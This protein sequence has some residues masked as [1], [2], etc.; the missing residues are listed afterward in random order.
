MEILAP[1]GNIVQAR[2]AVEAGCDALYG[3]P[4]QWN[5]RNRA[6]NFTV[7]EYN[8]IIEYCHKNGV[9]FYLTLNTLLKNEEIES[10]MTLLS[11]GDLILPDAVIVADVGLMIELKK[12][13]PS[14]LIHSSTQFGTAEIRD[15][16]FLESLG[17]NRAILARELLLPEIER[18]CQNTYMEI[19]VFVYGSQCISFSG[20]CLW[21]GLLN[22]ASGNRGRC[23]GMCRDLYDHCGTVGQFLYPQDI[24]AVKFRDKLEKMNVKSL[25]IEG[26]MRSGEEISSVI[27]VLKSSEICDAEQYT[28]YLLQ[29]VPVK[30][31]FNSVNPRTKYQMTGLE[32][33]AH[34]LL[35]DENMKY[36]FGSSFKGKDTRFV[37]CI[38]Y[39][40]LISG[41]INFAIKAIVSCDRLIKIDYINTYGERRMFTLAEE[42]D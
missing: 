24:N 30:E 15:I 42:S 11:S 14:L 38:Y 18:I 1:A 3:G 8:Q 41:S 2:F 21:G 26:R 6:D 10:I 35:I 23:I 36:T 9:R 34:D 19:E 33:T 28:G 7:D 13:F 22:G 16:R 29:I 5:A 17:V 40:P 12:Q 39:C 27:R 20:Q 4:K 32:M 25:K 31:M 37:K